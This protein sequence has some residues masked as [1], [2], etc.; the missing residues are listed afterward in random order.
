MELLLKRYKIL[1]KKGESQ[2]FLKVMDNLCECHTDAYIL[3]MCYKPLN[4]N[5]KVVSTVSL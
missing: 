4:C 3:L 2:S 1:V 5:L